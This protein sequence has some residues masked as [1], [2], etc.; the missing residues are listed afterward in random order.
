[1]SNPNRLE[2]ESSAALIRSMSYE[3]AVLGSI[4]LRVIGAPEACNCNVSLSVGVSPR[5][6]GL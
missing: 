3:P 1:M 2:A 6:K 5:T 4:S